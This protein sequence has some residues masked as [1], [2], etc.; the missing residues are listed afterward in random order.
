MLD[1]NQAIAEN[2]Q[3]TI[4][5]EIKTAAKYFSKALSISSEYID[6]Y[7]Y[8]AVCYLYLKE[9][10]KAKEIIAT[11]LAIMPEHEAAKELLQ[12]ANKETYEHLSAKKNL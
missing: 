1:L 3:D 6:A 12:Q 2:K 10:D 11:L 8:L 5:E 9:F 7:F 4:K